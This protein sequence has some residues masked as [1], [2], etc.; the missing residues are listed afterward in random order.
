MILMTRLQRIAVSPPV[1]MPDEKRFFNV[2]GNWLKVSG[3]NSTLNPRLKLRAMTNVAFLLISCEAIILM[4]AAATVPNMR[5]VAPPK[6]GPG[7]RLKIVPMTGK[8][9]RMMSIAA[10]K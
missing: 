2:V 6:T 5:S 9:P 3:T 8:R 7:I 10:M 1:V 4:P